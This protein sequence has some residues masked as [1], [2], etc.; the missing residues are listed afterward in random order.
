MYTHSPLRVSL[1]FQKYTWCGFLPPI[2]EPGW[3]AW[4]ARDRKCDV[5]EAKGGHPKKRAAASPELSGTGGG[6]ETGVCQAR[7]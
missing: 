6:A 3:G 4:G 1:S 7:P 5:S 2:D